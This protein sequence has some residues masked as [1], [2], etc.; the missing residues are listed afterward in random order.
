MKAI[1]RRLSVLEQR[2]SVK[3]R[4]MHIIKA[5]DEAD[6]RQQMS[7]LLA[8]GGANDGDGFLCL[9]GAPALH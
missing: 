2:K 8:A 9:T 7:E 5:M 3:S 6:G 1:E 4:Q